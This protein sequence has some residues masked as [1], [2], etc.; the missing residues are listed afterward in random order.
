VQ[1]EVLQPSGELHHRSAPPQPARGA[2][3][4]VRSCRRFASHAWER[5]RPLLSSG[6][7][8]PSSALDLQRRKGVGPLGEGEDKCP[9]AKI[10]FFSGSWQ[11]QVF[12]GVL[13]QILPL[14]FGKHL[15]V[16]PSVRGFFFAYYFPL[17]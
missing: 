7:P 12:N 16:F 15:V 13:W 5:R 17:I 6:R 2:L 3:A 8:S 4:A 11:K 14:V 9:P 1:G 10:V